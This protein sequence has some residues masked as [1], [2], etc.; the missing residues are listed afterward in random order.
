VGLSQSPSIWSLFAEPERTPTAGPSVTDLFTDTPP[1]E[2]F[3]QGSQRSPCARYFNEELVFWAMR[4]LPASEAVQHFL[5]CGS[6]GSGKTTAIQLFLQS[7]APRFRG[8]RER[9]EQLIIFDAKSELVSLLAGLG[10]APTAENVYLLNPDDERGVVWDIGEAVQTP[11]LARHFATLL[12]PEEPQSNAPFF[13]NSARLLVYAVILALNTI[14][15]TR[16]T[17]RDLLCALDSRRH[18]QAI[19]NRHPPSARVVEPFLKD[20]KHFDAILSSVAS[21]VGAFDQVAALWHSSRNR[22]RFS[23]PE[24][25]A[26]P[27]VL[28][29]SNDPVL[30]DSF[31]PV[32][33]ILLKA[34]T[35]E[36]LRG[37]EVREPRHWFVFDEFPA[38]RNVECIKDLL[39]RGRSKG[40]SVLLGTQGVEH[41]NEV[42]GRDGAEAIL[43][44]CAYKTFLRAGGPATAE[45]TQR[46]FGTRRQ[47]ESQWSESWGKDG[48]S[49]SVQYRVEERSVF[50]SSFF[51]NLPF[52]RAGGPYVA[53]NDVPCL[54]STLISRRWFDQLLSWRSK[55]AGVANTIPRPNIKEQ[56]LWPWTPEEAAAFCGKAGSASKSEPKQ[57]ELPLESSAEPP[58]PEAA[59]APEAPK[60]TGL[61]SREDLYGGG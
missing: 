49:A 21:K 23:I 42:Y 41:L 28:I 9:P 33:A 3:R 52:P 37:A 40:V 50:T 55:P 17:F 36:I 48:H 13:P 7:I 5:V 57:P 20:E 60:E 51:L 59:D 47:M 31:W 15:G 19:T 26:R 4:N 27:G 35:H 12:I 22:H 39:D 18:I 1:S 32:S 54:G 53:V 25:L 38:M 2:S 56:T 16:W 44:Q 11:A 34:L 30:K 45:W 6:T 14:A 8:D 43:G 29:L 61:M 58:A 10:F 46:Y 24:F